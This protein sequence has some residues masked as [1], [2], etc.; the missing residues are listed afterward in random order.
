MAATL[1]GA[2]VAAA[3]SAHLSL[4]PASVVD[5]GA[6][7]VVVATLFAFRPAEGVGAFLLFALVANPLQLLL[8]ADLRYFDEL[9]L[10]VLALT[11]IVVHRVRLPRQV[12]GTAEWAVAGIVV[13]GVASSLFA[14]D[15]PQIWIPGLLL[16]LKGVGFFYL[17]WRLPLRLSEVLSV[18][19]VV[20][21]AAVI[22]L[23]LAAWEFT[24]PQAFQSLIGLPPYVAQRGGLTVVKSVFDHPAVFGWITV[25][26]SLFIYA[27]VIIRRTWWLLP[28]G[29]AFNAGTIFSG[30]RTPILGLV[31]AL[32][33]A[34]VWYA[35][36]ERSAPAV[37]R[38]WAPMV[39]AVGL[40]MAAFVPAVGGFY[41]DTPGQYL[42][43]PHAI[44]EI[45][46]PSPDPSVVSQVQ[47]R[48][49]L[50]VGAVA[51]ARDHF[52]LGAGL[53]RWG[54]YMSRL[55]YSPLYAQYGVDMISGLSPSNRDSID[56]TFWP[57]VLGEAG[58][59]GLAAFAV[60]VGSVL[61]RLWN[62]LTA[63]ES[64]M[65]Q[66]FVLGGMLIFIQ[67]IVASLSAGTY[68]APPIAY[69]VLGTAGAVLAVTSSQTASDRSV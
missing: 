30:R 55:H 65:S 4:Q 48:T 59:L 38:T 16:L 49:A 63:V 54:S 46:G 3:L 24:D 8:P 44:V 13:A 6:A 42:D 35:W 39:A 11:G 19:A 36:R 43:A 15:P 32:V 31:L 62:S 10:V 45:L 18:G 7:V 29:L 61:V 23:V 20:L 56:D 58:I 67:G 12:L 9:G 25:F 64:P 22:L 57:S 26:A 69:W 34:L 50:Y 28:L 1:A 40:L 60:F 68:V 21:A 52:P 37:L 53:G 14:G 5:A 17:V 2:I 47:P 41:S 27:W 33:V 66:A 51:I